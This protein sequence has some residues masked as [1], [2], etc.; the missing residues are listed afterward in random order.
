MKDNTIEILTAEEMR[1]VI[2]ALRGEYTE[3]EAQI[4]V[5]WA[6]KASID[7]AMLEGV[8]EGKIELTVREGEVVFHVCDNKMS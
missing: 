8:L 2:A 5:D 3:E 7:E 4:V 6:I 1:T